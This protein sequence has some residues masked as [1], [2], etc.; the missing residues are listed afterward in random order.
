MPSALVDARGPGRVQDARFTDDALPELGRGFMDQAPRP[1]HTS[2]AIE[3]LQALARRKW[4]LL[5]VAGMVAALGALVVH[6]LKPQYTAT[7]SVVVEAAT[8]DPLTPTAPSEV[9]RLDDDRVATEALQLASRDLARSVVVALEIGVT[10]PPPPPLDR[11]LCNQF[12]QAKYCV[13]P[14]APTLAGRIDGFLGHLTVEPQPRSRILTISY[15]SGDADEA[16]AAVNLLVTTYQQRQLAGQSGDLSRVAGW[17]GDRTEALRQK[18]LAA[19]SAANAF[20]RSH[21]I[22][23]TGAGEQNTPLVQRQISDA[24][25]ELSQAQ[26]RLA[27]A[28]ARADQLGR[29][30][31]S[32]DE[33]G[34][35]ALG[36]QPVLVG[37]A[38]SLAQLRTARAQQ[39]ATLGDR[40][41]SVV[42]L[43]DQIAEARARLRDQIGQA[44]QAVDADVAAHRA[45]VAELERNLAQLRSTA[46]ED[47]GTEVQYRTLDREAQS[48]RSVYETFAAREKQVA[49]R[50]DILRPPVAFVSHAEVPEQPSF[51]HRGKLYL[52][53]LALGLTLGA[54]AAFAAEQ[55][56]RGFNDIGQIRAQIPWPLLTVVPLVATRRG[57]VARFVT[58][59]PF[60]RAA[61]SVRTLA[62]QLVLAGGARR[63]QAIA[64]ASAGAQ[65]GKSTVTLWL[66]ASM[67][68]TGQRVLV[69]DGDHRHPSLHRG[70]NA[71]N[72]SG[73]TDILAG[74]L[75]VQKVLQTEVLPGVDFIASGPASGRPLGGAELQRLQELIDHLKRGYEVI[76]IDTP[77]ML[78][79]GD[80]L[81]LANVADQ[82]V[83]LC[84]WQTTTRAAVFG[85][86]ERLHSAGARI[87]GVVV[88]M[89]NE[90]RLP[91]YATDLTRRDRRLLA[92]TY[93]E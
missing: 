51:P 50:V 76:L 4:L 87:S 29:A 28:Q 81:M 25:T 79:M 61:E 71:Q 47:S 86:L 44:R 73:L 20:G 24:A 85:C 54:V 27:A 84:R 56:A 89:M 6:G 53:A 10:P 18:W 72:E 43:N 22:T 30:S 88:S 48:A 26:S 40:H 31:S 14:V 74:R 41:P 3:L 67:A 36:D 39:A 8:P 38:A 35:I 21:G 16:A 58:E 1:R 49:D 64:I 68:Q 17:V 70:L 13:T 55:L 57:A 23:T 91:L 11:V 34:L 69:L 5:L 65:E 2:P 80:A 92:R 19:E 12:H 93:A 45:E 59:R 60:S 37:T 77:P 90:G 75:P 62:A 32:G 7:A 33:R 78:A 46:T 15:V 42:A 66:A 63:E 83:F 9:N 82:T 52:G